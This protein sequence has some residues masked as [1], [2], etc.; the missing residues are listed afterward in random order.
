[1]D[2]S[3]W[4]ATEAENYVVRNE[5]ET[6]HIYTFHIKEDDQELEDKI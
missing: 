5:G 6:T 2:I 1:V 3:A 4:L